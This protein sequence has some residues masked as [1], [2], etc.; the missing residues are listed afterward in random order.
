MV[1]VTEILEHW[2]A[3]RPQWRALAWRTTARSRS[4]AA[5]PRS[6]RKSSPAASDCRSDQ[7]LYVARA[8]GF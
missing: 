5:P 8:T 1:D 4:S 2:Y 6:R 7:A 3:G